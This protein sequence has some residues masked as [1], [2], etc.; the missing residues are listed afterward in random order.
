[1][2]Q[3]TIKYPV[4]IQGICLHS[5]NISTVR[6]TPSLSGT[7][8]QFYLTS[9]K[10]RKIINLNSSSI[11]DT[12]LSTNISESSCSVSTIEHLMS[13]LHALHIDNLQISVYGD[14]IPILDGSSINYYNLIKSADYQEQYDD[15][16]YITINKDIEYISDSGFIKMSPY[17]GLIIDMSIVFDNP[18]IGEQSFI[19]DFDKDDYEHDIAPART[20]GIY[21][22]IMKAIKMGLIKG[23]SMDNAVVI[24][25]DG[26]MNKEGL[27]YFNEFVRHKILDFIGDIYINGP[28]KGYF[29]VC[30]SG[31]KMT[32]EFMNILVNKDNL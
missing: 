5:G 32:N 2:K 12:T 3:R 13:V 18:Y 26:I 28:I 17:D 29:N 15:R 16:S 4:S 21:E 25:S 31:H 8:I 20:F 9:H 23:G 11:I 1:M 27:R 22:D 6:M 30:C 10:E 19:F 14:G 7:G 24:N